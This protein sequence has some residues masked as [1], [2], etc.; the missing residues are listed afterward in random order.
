MRSVNFTD[1]ELL[2]GLISRD[3]R[4]LREFYVLYFKSI[5][6]YVLA[7][8]GNNEDARDLFQDVMLV[9]F[10]KVRTGNFKLT[11]ALG[12]FLFSVSRFLW[13]KELGKRKWVSYT[14]VDHEDFVDTDSD[15]AAVNEKNER[16]IFFR[17]CFDKLSESCRK[18]LTLF[19]EG[20]SIAEITKM[21]GYKSE[22]HTK[23]RRYRCKLS[24]I[25]NIKAEYDYNT[26]S[27]GNNKNH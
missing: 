14:P 13:L 12:T 27:Y 5:Q 1:S 17:R 16:L 26:M 24:L 22:Q 23:N 18:V 3:K 6:R 2:N 11:C 4:I 8:K 21:L 15:I 9:M 19:T 7:N 20:F 10:Q 25:N